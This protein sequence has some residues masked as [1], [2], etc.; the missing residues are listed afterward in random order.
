MEEPMT[1]NRAAKGIAAPLWCTLVGLGHTST[2]LLNPE[3]E[4][5]RDARDGQAS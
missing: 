1:F 2:T 3:F 5:S 4:Q